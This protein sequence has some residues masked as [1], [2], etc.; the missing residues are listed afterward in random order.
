MRIR[1]SRSA[2]GSSARPPIAGRRSAWPSASGSSSPTNGRGRMPSAT[3]SARTAT[4]SSSARSTSGPTRRISPVGSR[5]GSRASRLPEI[6]APYYQEVE[7][8]A[9]SE[10][11]DAIGHLDFVKRY[12]A[13]HIT[14]ADLAT[15]PELLEP[16]L[17]ALVEIGDRARDQ[18]QRPAPGTR[19]DVSVGGHGRPLPRARRL[20]GVG[21]VRCACR[22]PLRL[23][24]V[25]RLRR[26]RGRRPA[27]VAGA[28]PASTPELGSL[29][30]PHRHRRRTLIHGSAAGHRRRVPAP[31]GGPR[32]PAG[33]R[34]GSFPGLAGRLDPATLDAVL[35]SHLHPDHFIDL[36][37]LR[38]YLRWEAPRGRRVRVIGPAGLADRIDALHAE[39]GFTP[40]RSTSRSSDR[41][42]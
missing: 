42:S 36:V 2:G 10:L 22:P 25:G 34:P 20:P 32:H 19:R 3:T 1:P 13:P 38:H 39:P 28:P 9:R 14:A 4:T 21:R 27:T 37:S 40:R 30:G 6:V 23:G 17:R 41:A 35:V 29:R 33:P 26:G 5:P 15:A 11:F 31:R 24:P 7:A 8:A 16:V 12:L 18:Y